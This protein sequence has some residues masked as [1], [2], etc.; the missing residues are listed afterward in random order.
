MVVT[1]DGKSLTLELVMKVADEGEKVKV[2]LGSLRRM[3]RFRA[4]LEEKVN[5]GQVVYGV[6]TGIGSLSNTPVPIEMLK[7]HQLDLIRSHSAGVGKP[8]EKEV[9]R[10][11]MLLRLNSLVKGNSAVRPEV[12]TLLSE[13]LNFGVTPLVP[14]FGSLGASGD[15]IPSAHVALTMVGEGKAYH[16]GRLL[17]SDQALKRAG[18]R[19]IELAAKE[20]LSL[21]NGTCFSAAL[22]AICVQRGKTLLETANCSVALTGEA[23]GAYIGSFDPRLV[24]LKRNRGQESVAKQIRG[25]LKGSNRIK[26]E[27]LPQDPYSIRCAPQVHGALKD[28]L[29]FAER[30]TVEEANSVSDNPVFLEDGTV[31]HGGNFH[32]QSVAMASDLLSFSVAYV[33][34]MSLARTHLLLARSPPERKYMASRPGLESGLMILEYAASALAADNAKQSYPLSAYPANV[35]GGIEDHAS[36]GVNAGLKALSVGENV[37]RMLAIEMICVSNLVGQ[38][39]RGLAKFSTRVYERVRDI[40]PLLTGD[41]SQSGEIS[42]LSGEILN[43]KLPHP[44][45][46]E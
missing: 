43:G 5:S 27:P 12:A 42:D 7:Q 38:D 37:S 21:I 2:G 1:L 46:D 34:T 31:L 11:A 18:L 23:L 15:L 17:D 32:A 33:G 44:A 14:E 45:V 36:Y 28:A 13:M 29:E 40:S 24:R 22:A 4:V 25:M 10:A 3:D 26:A 16:R 30:L 20:G 35:S 39:L 6:N 8:M 19:P 41:R 9:V